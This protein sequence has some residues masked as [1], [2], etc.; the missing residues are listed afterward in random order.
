VVAVT[1]KER[2]VKGFQ[3]ML[4]AD[5]LRLLAKGGLIVLLTRFLLEPA[6]YGLLFLTMAV[7]GIA[8]LLSTLGVPKSGARYVT[9]YAET[10]PGQVPHILRFVLQCNLVLIAVVSV[11]LVAFRG[12]IAG[13]VDSPEMAPML[14]L[15]VGFLVARSLES[16]LM[17]L[18]QGLNT[19]TWT[20]WMK[21]V[22]SVSQPVL[23]AAFVLAGLGATGALLGFTLAA[24]LGTAVGL[25]VLYLHF[26]RGERADSIE[27]GLRRRIL[28]YSIPLSA[29]HGA[30]LLYYRVDTLLI[31]YFLSPTAVGFY[32]LAKQIS[33]FVMKP[34][35]ALGFTVSP[36]FG[37][38]K[39]NGDLSL[40]AQ[41]YETAFVHTVIIYVP[42]IAGMALVARPAVEFIF[43]SDYLGAVPVIQ[44]FALYT[45]LVT[46]DNITNSGLDYLGRANARA[47]AKGGTAIANLGL[48]VA[49]IPRY[50]IVGAAV[51]TVVSFSVL[52]AIELFVMYRELPL[53]VGRMARQFAIAVGVSIGMSLAVRFLIPYVSGLPSLVGVVSIGVAV[54]AVLAVGSGVLDLRQIRSL[55]S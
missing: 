24:G 5:V 38:H 20:A 19:V 10:K 30:E 45:L 43:G 23:A 15:G 4:V 52:V 17:V 7:L 42:A 6:E 40:A 25:V 32:T 27:S 50:G 22:D 36:Q 49:L 47:L 35:A 11:G 26:Y 34:A 51:A 9:E 28:K 13:L 2:L 54:W 48:N 55:L 53:S 12:R 44:V 41:L 39:T 33:E 3:A 21:T 46:I 31:G 29:T 8:K 1:T 14:V 37:T 16:S 18:F